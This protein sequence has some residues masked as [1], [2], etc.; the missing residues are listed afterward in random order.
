MID[1]ANG[2][3]IKLSPIA[4]ESV[5]GRVVEILRQDEKILF[6]AKGIRDSLILTDKRLIASNVQGMTGKKV[7]LTSIAYSR[8]AS[9]STESAGT[10]DND[11]ELDIWV[12]GIGKVRFE[13]TRGTDLPAISRIFAHY[14]L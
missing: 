8:I 11:S 6:A 2:S 1:F 3:F 12:A 13:F 10:L 9:F 4:I 7:D 5:D 14:V